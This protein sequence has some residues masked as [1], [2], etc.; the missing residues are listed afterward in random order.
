MSRSRDAAPEQGDPCGPTVADADH[1]AAATRVEL[2]PPPAKRSH[3]PE[4]PCPRCAG[5]AP[6]HRY[7]L[8]HGSYSN[9]EIVGDVRE[10]VEALYP[11]LPAPHEADV[12]LVEAL[13]TALVRK[14][15][16]EAEL[17]RADRA[18]NLAEKESLSR[19]MRGWVGVVM[20]ACERLGLSPTSRAELGLAHAQTARTEAEA[21][22][23]AVDLE[24][25]RLERLSDV[26][27]Q[28]LVDALEAATRDGEHR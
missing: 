21:L 6:G 19:D 4:C 7:A 26:Q 5:F 11:L 16:A 10:L 24:R 25:V 23:A 17:D 2:E 9:V 1:G 28:G 18:G 20:R 14:R 12:V 22:L 8:D 3:G 27:L 15:R 13:A